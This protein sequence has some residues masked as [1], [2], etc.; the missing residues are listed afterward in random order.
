ENFED[1]GRAIQ[2][3]RAPGLLEIALLYRREL[4][5]DDDNLGLEGAR[6]AG[7]LVDLSTSDQ[8]CRRGMHKWKDLCRHHLQADRR[9]ETDSFGQA[10]RRVTVDTSA[11]GTRFWLDV[12]NNRRPRRCARAVLSATADFLG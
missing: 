8:G 6:V 1:Q 5:I 10:H 3:L 11:C 4:G 7:N 2:D 12:H 9:G